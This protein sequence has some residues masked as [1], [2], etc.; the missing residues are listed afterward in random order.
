MHELP[1]LQEQYGRT[2]ESSSEPLFI[3]IHPFADGQ[4][5][6]QL[7]KV[8]KENGITFPVMVDSPDTEVRSWGRTFKKY[9]VFGIPTKVS[10]D[11]NGHFA[12]IDEELI[13]TSSWWFKNAGGK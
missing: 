10:I 12:E 4:N 2:V 1:Q 3:S 6:S 5:L 13:T 7:K 11:E 9:R 8:I